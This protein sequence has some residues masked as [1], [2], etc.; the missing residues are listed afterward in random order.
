VLEDR[1]A[2]GLEMVIEHHAG[3]LVLQQARKRSLALLQRLAAQVLAVRF[4]QVEGAQDGSTIV[5]LADQVKH[6]QPR[7]AD[8]DGLAVDQTRPHR[9]VVDGVGDPGEARREVVTVAGE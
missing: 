4:D 1:S 3:A 8:H 9:E 2:V 7:R 5:L 6:R